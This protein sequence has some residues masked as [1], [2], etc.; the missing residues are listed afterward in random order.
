MILP[1]I[2]DLPTAKRRSIPMVL[3]HD[4]CAV[5][6]RQRRLLGR[7]ALVPR[8]DL[9]R[10]RFHAV[11]DWIEFRVCIGRNT[12]VQHVQNVLRRNLDRNSHIVAESKGPGDVFS[13]CTIKVQEPESLALINVIYEDIAETFGEAAESR[14]TGIEVSIDAYSTK[15]SY[16]DRISLLGALQRTLWC[17]RDIWSKPDSRPRMIFGGGKHEVVKLSP[18]PEMDGAGVSR[19]VP[20]GHRVPAVDGT[21]YL[22]A[23]HDPVMIRVMDKV[24]DRQHP[25]G[26]SLMLAED[27]K[28]A[29]VEVTLKGDELWALGLTSVRSLDG[30]RLA[31]LQKRYFQFRLPTF[32]VRTT[33][34]KAADALHNTKQEWRARTYLQAGVTGLFTMDAATDA[35]RSKMARG[36]RKTFRSLNLLQRRSWGGRRLEPPFVSW[37]Q[38]N[39]KVH[40]ALRDLEKRERTAW[41]KRSSPRNEGKGKQKKTA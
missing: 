21:M 40:L 10:F 38:M 19:S 26:T 39:R 30:F 41:K 18:G 24:I 29:R 11:I 25:S 15:A 16:T 7:T 1:T 13:V 35:Q 3:H 33:V 22:G 34:A 14:I 37:E 2:A 9:E 31:T 27:R 12:Q 28:R 32:S 8:V 6:K 23:V 5:E 20:E 17:Q 4:A 36:M